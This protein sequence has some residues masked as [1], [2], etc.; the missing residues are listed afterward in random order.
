[1]LYSKNSRDLRIYRYFFRINLGITVVMVLRVLQWS[2]Q[3]ITNT[4]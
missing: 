4:H 3:T 2:Y 1:M